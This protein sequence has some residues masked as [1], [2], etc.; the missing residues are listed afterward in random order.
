MDVTPDVS[1]QNC[2][3]S[4]IAFWTAKGGLAIL[5]QGLFAGTNFVV[6]ILLARWLAPAEYGAFALAFAIFLLAGMFHTALMTEPMM[7]FGSGKYLA[8]FKAY[9]RLL[10]RVHWGFTGAMSLLLLCAALL[11]GWIDSALVGWALAGAALA[12]P[13]ILFLWLVRRA[14]YV[15]LR[16][17]WTAAGGVLY[18]LLLLP[19]ILALRAAGFLAPV[20]SLAA[21][22]GAALAVATLLIF[23]LPLPQA[24]AGE[25][26]R[27]REAAMDHW[28][29]GRWAAATA[30]LAWFPNSI[31]FLLLPV[32]FGLAEAGALKALMNLS[33]PILQ[34]AT[35]LGVLLLP[36]LVRH[37]SEGGTQRMAA[38]VRRFLALFLSGAALYGLLLWAFRYQ[39]LAILYA[40]NYARYVSWP[41]LLAALLPVAA[42][43]ALPFDSALRA[44]ERPDLIFK[45]Y[46]A[47]TVASLLCGLPLA[48][49]LGAG[50]GLAG[51]VVFWLVVVW[52]TS[53]QCQKQSPQVETGAPEPVL[54][55]AVEGS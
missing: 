11:G 12:A 38:T 46:G 10:F 2:S 33:M 3:A 28:R 13:C 44:L 9:R 51:M 37:R 32:R 25:G 18:G 47:A 20:T 14:F 42:C 4:R 15:C 8:R 48:A 30:S 19:L 22:S 34:S 43:A 5:D 23:R 35:A 52:L 31:Y 39:V 50:G 49:K 41:L 36:L 27:L 24:R 45:S 29:Y 17:A 1:K 6:N 16:P 26:P 7:V 54:E 21:M 55:A 53:R 40:G